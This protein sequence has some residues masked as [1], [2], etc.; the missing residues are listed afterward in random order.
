MWE[1]RRAVPSILVPLGIGLQTIRK[2]KLKNWEWNIYVTKLNS[3]L[4]KW[5]RW[6]AEPS[7]PCESSIGLIPSSAEVTRLSCTSPSLWDTS[8][9]K[10]S[11][12]MVESYVECHPM[13]SRALYICFWNLRVLFDNCLSSKSNHDTSAGSLSIVTAFLLVKRFT[14]EK[15]WGKNWVPNVASTQNK[16]KKCH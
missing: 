4:R 8:A 10:V 9:L 3:S 13:S 2:V 14:T 1:R 12:F 7:M 15:S 5:F 16:T 6:R 11:R